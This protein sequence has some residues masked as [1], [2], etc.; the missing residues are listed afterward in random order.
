MTLHNLSAPLSVDCTGAYIEVEREN[1]GFEA[2]WCGDRVRETGSRPHLVFARGE[3][4]IAVHSAD[5]DAAPQLPVGFDAEVEVID[6]LD[7]RQYA[8]FRRSG[9]N[10]RR[11]I[12]EPVLPQSYPSRE[13]AL[14]QSYPS[15]EPVLPQS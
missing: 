9:L 6:L 14:P 10:F 15:Q 8:N 2:R 13:P 7:A 3:V 4:R 5:R 12:Q 1:D 11:L